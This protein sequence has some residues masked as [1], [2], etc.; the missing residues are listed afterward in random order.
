MENMH[1]IQSPAAWQNYALPL[2]FTILLVFLNVFRKE[3]MPA[4]LGKHWHRMSGIHVGIYLFRDVPAPLTDPE[5]NHFLLF[6]IIRH[7]MLAS[8]VLG[9]YIWRYL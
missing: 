3:E 6:S 7:D 9:T 1:L 4:F 2:T 8:G 5:K